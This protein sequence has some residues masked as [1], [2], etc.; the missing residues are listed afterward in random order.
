MDMHKCTITEK[1]LIILFKKI[2]CVC[3]EGKHKAK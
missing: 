2:L 3:L 1:E